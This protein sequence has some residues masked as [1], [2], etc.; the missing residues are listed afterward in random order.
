MF[1]GPKI[2]QLN[3]ADRELA[4]KINTLLKEA[5]GPLVTHNSC[6]AGKTETLAIIL[7]KVNIEASNLKTDSMRGVFQL[8]VRQ[9]DSEEIILLAGGQSE[10]GKGFAKEI[11]ILLKDKYDRHQK[12]L[13]TACSDIAAKFPEKVDQGLIT[14][15]L[16]HTEK[17]SGTTPGK[18]VAGFGK[19][20]LSGE[21]FDVE[22]YFSEPVRD[23]FSKKPKGHQ[24]VFEVS[25]ANGECME[26]LN[27]PVV[28][29][30]FSKLF[31][32]IS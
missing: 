4:E 13:K 21:E 7:D 27:G 31:P 30:L 17:G 24:L 5:C 25:S 22:I 6:R 14:S 16:F 8:T 11:F 29:E 2:K 28:E 23:S 19:D 9:T 3:P 1:K 32:D 12:A 15:A 20:V 26:I 10:K 18:R